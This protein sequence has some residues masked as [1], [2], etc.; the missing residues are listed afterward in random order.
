MAAPSPRSL[1]LVPA[2]PEDVDSILELE[3]ASYPADEAAD[4]AKLL[5]RIT[6]APMFFMKALDGSSL[7]GFVN[8]T[9]ATEL[10]EESMSSHEPHG[11]VLC[12]HSVVVDPAH[13]SKGIATWM[14]LQYL[15]RSL[16]L[17]PQVKQCALLSKAHNARLYE[18]CGFTNLGPSGVDHGSETWLLM[19]RQVLSVE[20]NPR[21]FTVLSSGS[22]CL[23]AVTP[24]SEGVAEWA[25]R[26][27]SD[28]PLVICSPLPTGGWG[29]ITVDPTEA[30]P[31][32]SERPA[33]SKAVM[34]VL[35]GHGFTHHLTASVSLR[36][37]GE[38]AIV[39]TGGSPTARVLIDGRSTTRWRAE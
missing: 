23:L 33:V 1:A 28:A 6:K 12:I 32:S 16:Q 27:G 21:M 30:A 26:V 17:C 18:R 36:I 9:L 10:T 14:V 20:R 22:P 11:T 24:E 3:L 15:E 31:A 25:D 39:P 8:G 4:R 34:A 38:E 35:E 5:L 7:V 19:T 13:R 37:A 29:V 2:L